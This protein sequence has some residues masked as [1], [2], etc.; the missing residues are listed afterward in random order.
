MK[1]RTAALILALTLPGL[2]LVASPDSRKDTGRP[3]GTG[4]NSTLSSYYY[5]DADLDAG[6][7]MSI[8][9][10]RAK[11]GYS[12]LFSTQSRAS[13][14]FTFEWR[15]YS[16]GEAF[17][18]WGKTWEAGLSFSWFRELD[19]DWSLL[20]TPSI[21]LS[22]EDGASLSDAI[23]IGSIVAFTKEFSPSLRLG[24]GAGVYTGLEDTRVFPFIMIRWQINEQWYVGNPFAPG[25]V[26]PAGLELGYRFNED[27]SFAIGGAYRSDRFRLTGTGTWA[28]GYGDFEGVPVFLRTTYGMMWDTQIHFYIGTILSG[29][30][31]IDN[32]A[33]QT[34]LSTDYDPAI[35]SAIAWEGT[36]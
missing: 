11:T 24:L 19:N 15:D 21:R 6:G 5:G 36:F 3:P 13:A 4:W 34:Q 27:W 8:S 28:D 2:C 9:S 26:G 31:E 33:G 30:L 14:D 17:D 7:S 10:I 29:Q 12:W 32:D 35:L 25:P 16:F 20:V 22:M 1:P 23:D 18:P